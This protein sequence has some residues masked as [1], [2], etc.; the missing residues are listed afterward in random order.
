MTETLLIEI[1]RIAVGPRLR[2]VDA[3]WVETL[4]ASIAEHGLISPV[5]IGTADERGNYPLIAGAHRLAA[6][7]KLGKRTIPAVINERDALGMRLLEIDENLMRRELSALDRGVFLSERKE[8]WEALHPETRHGGPRIRG[9]VAS[10]STCFERYSA[11]AARR[12]GTGERTIQRMVARAGRIVPDV[13]ARIS[14]HQISDN[15][16]ELDALA[17]LSPEEQRAVVEFLFGP[18]AV[19]TVAA[20]TAKYRGESRERAERISQVDRVLAQWGRCTAEEQRT[21]SLHLRA[22][23]RDL[24]GDPS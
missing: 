17:E 12:L 21:L 18:D 6:M 9:Q 22:T 23:R 13:R 20:A 1:A 14:S 8:V 24:F 15:G 16:R 11:E 5:Q 19:A 3:G 2:G 10:V 4:A 7:A